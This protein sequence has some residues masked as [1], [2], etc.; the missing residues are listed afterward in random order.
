M[1]AIIRVREVDLIGVVHA[2]LLM[3]IGAYLAVGLN[4]TSGYQR[5]IVVGSALPLM[6]MVRWLS[7][8]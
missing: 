8:N 5:P 6:L 3:V 1:K 2:A 7:K 4:V